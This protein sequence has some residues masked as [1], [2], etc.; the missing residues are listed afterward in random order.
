MRGG[1]HRSLKGS[2]FSPSVSVGTCLFDFV[3]SAIANVHG[4]VPKH[5]YPQETIT[6]KFSNLVSPDRSQ[7]GSD[8]RRS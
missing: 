3:M 4:V 5:R 7:H 1:A 2:L 8:R 6:E